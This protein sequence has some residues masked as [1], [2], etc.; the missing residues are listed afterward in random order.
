MLHLQGPG[1][2]NHVNKTAI[3]EDLRGKYKLF[4]ILFASMKIQG[5]G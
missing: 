4:S 3:K 5:S 2:T 1:I